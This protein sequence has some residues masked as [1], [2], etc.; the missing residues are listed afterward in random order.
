MNLIIHRLVP[1]EGYLNNVN[2]GIVLGGEYPKK[3]KISSEQK[4][5]E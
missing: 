2:L 1:T 4:L 5:S 3:D